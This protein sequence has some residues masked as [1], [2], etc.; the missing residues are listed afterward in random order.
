MTADTVWH[1]LAAI[2]SNF[3]GDGFYNLRRLSWP[4]SFAGT[5]MEH[6]AAA[7][8][9][10]CGSRE[11]FHELF[12]SGGKSWAT[13]KTLNIAHKYFREIKETGVLGIFPFGLQANIIQVSGPQ[14]RCIL[15]ILCPC[16]LA[17]EYQSLHSTCST[18]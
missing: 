10:H 18:V 17:V 12:S 11:A 13:M 2:G 14:D 15:T 9:F 3:D 6:L 5:T 16:R 4:S 1:T 8:F 7:D